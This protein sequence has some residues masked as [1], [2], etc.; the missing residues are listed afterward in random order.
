LE[1]IV[2]YVVQQLSLDKRGKMKVKSLFWNALHLVELPPLSKLHR[3]NFYDLLV[4][5]YH[6]GKCDEKY[7]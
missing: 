6:N 5:A 1:V 2:I 3:G 4:I 7:K